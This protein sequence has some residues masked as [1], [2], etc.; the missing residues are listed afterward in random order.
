MLINNTPIEEY[1]DYDTSVHYGNGGK[2][3]GYFHFKDLSISEV[4]LL[5]EFCNLA[6][7][8]SPQKLQSIFELIKNNER[9]I[10]EVAIL[11]REYGQDRAIK[12]MNK[13]FS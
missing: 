8:H 10:E 9:L 2:F 5:K 7:R 11:E 4:M 12:I 6:R 13:D 3:K 1:S